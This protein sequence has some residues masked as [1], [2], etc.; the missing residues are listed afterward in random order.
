M[1]HKPENITNS[2]SK[3]RNVNIIFPGTRNELSEAVIESCSPKKDV[4]PTISNKTYEVT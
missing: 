1:K 2:E 4:F 3:Y